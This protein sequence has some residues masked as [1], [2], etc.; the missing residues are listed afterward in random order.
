MVS[1]NTTVLFLGVFVSDCEDQGPDGLLV[2]LPRVYD[3]RTDLARALLGS[4][5]NLWCTVAAGV[6]S[7]ITAVRF[8]RIRILVFKCSI[9]E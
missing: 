4:T 1:E 3:T 2:D 7:K 8:D 6:D 9:P 5:S